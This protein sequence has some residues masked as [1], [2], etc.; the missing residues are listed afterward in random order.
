MAGSRA[1]P[2][3]RADLRGV[4]ALLE[5]LVTEPPGRTRPAR[6]LHPGGRSVLLGSRSSRGADFIG[7]GDAVASLMGPRLYRQF[8]LPYEQRIIQAVHEAGA[9]VKLHI[10]G[11]TARQ[12]A[13]M[14]KA[15]ADIIDVDWMVPLC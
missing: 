8:A 12:L 10:C 11:N 4:S 1:Q 9:K 7:V 14:A 2:L 3:R 5:D 15:G 6:N 13:D